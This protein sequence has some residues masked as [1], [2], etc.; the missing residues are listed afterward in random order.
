MTPFTRLVST[1]APLPEADID[2]DIIFPARF[3]L[4][5]TRQGLGAHAFHDRRYD[6]AGRERAD[7]VLHR[8]PWRGAHILLAGANFGCGSSREQAPWALA[9]LGL[10]C[11]IA[12]SFGEI[13]QANCWANGI[14]PLPLQGASHQRVLAA[15]LAGQSVAVDLRLCKLELADGDIAFQ[16]PQ[17]QRQALL[18]GLDDI[19]LLL[20]DHGTQR[21][22]FE[23]AHA[24]RMPWL[25]DST[26]PAAAEPFNP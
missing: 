10:R 15:A 26:P 20:R 5:T 21:A 12:P 9:D 23:Q 8:E 19:G 13:F 25:F 22:V 4:L 16:V 18:A 17:R 7:F 24:Q 2:T 1:V 3:L 11:V 14:L 6:S